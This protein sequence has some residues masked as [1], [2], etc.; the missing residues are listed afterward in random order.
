MSSGWCDQVINQIQVMRWWKIGLEKGKKGIWQIDWRT[1]KL[2]SSWFNNWI[3]ACYFFPLWMLS[4]NKTC[5]DVLAC[6]CFNGIH[7]VVSS[8]FWFQNVSLSLKY[9]KPE[10]LPCMKHLRTNECLLSRKVE[11]LP[12]DINIFFEKN[13]KENMSFNINM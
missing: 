8:L 4:H 9:D 10:I 2:R 12:L 3:L 1:G 13:A 11:C 7:F 5:L 6:S